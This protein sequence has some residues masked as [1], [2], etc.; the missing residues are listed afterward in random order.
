MQALIHPSGVVAMPSSS[1]AAAEISLDIEGMSCAS[2]VMRVEKALKKI[3]GVTEV[4]VNLATERASIATAEPVA[5]AALI[6]AIEK[7]GYQAHQHIPEE[8][9]APASTKKQLPSW[10][11]VAVPVDPSPPKSAPKS[12]KIRFG[13]SDSHILIRI[14]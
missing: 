2:C 6:A 12:I 7:A 10:W 8:T 1:P 4:S 11:P 13:N 9:A 5:P 14:F 3:P